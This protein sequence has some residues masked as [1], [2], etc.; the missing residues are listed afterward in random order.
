[1]PRFTITGT[2]MHTIMVVPIHTTETSETPD[3][4]TATPTAANT[5]TEQLTAAG[6]AI[7]H[8][9]FAIIDAEVGQH[10]YSDEQWP[11]VRRIIHASADFEFN[12]LTA[13]HPDAMRAGLACPEG[14]H[15]D[16]RRC[17]NDLRRPFGATPQHFGMPP[18]TTF[19]IRR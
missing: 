6:R 9:S 17:R 14:R 16:R 7:E 3:M 5:I 8:D 15:A 10:D 2:P 11:L 18:S 12:G 19:P 13:F 1:M 4:T